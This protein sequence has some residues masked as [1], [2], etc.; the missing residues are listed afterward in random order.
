MY[1]TKQRKQPTSARTT[2]QRKVEYTKIHVILSVVQQFDQRNVGLN[3]HAR[4]VHAQWDRLCRYGDTTH[5][6]RQITVYTA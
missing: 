5:A 1:T 3:V 4:D 2:R 6:I